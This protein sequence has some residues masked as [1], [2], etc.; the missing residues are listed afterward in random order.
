MGTNNGNVGKKGKS[1]RKSAYQEMADAT[2]LFEAFN[3]GVRLKDI[4]NTIELLAALFPKEKTKKAIRAAEEE[5][6]K[7]RN[8]KL[9]YIDLVLLRSI[10]NPKVLIAL[11]LKVFPDKFDNTNDFKGLGDMLVALKEGKSVPQPPEEPPE[12]S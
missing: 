12:K 10:Q 7:K 2:R 11:M 3:D 1:G 4:R 6:K 5:F 8:K 9:K